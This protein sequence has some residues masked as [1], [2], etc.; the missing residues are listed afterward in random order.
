MSGSELIDLV[1][2]RL[3]EL[4]I[5]YDHVALSDKPRKKIM[6]IIDGKRIDFGAKGS[7][8]WLEGASKQKRD[9]YR[10]RA[11]KITN[12][13]GEYTYLIRYTPNFLAYNILW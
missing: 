2:K 11:S 3:R 7:N 8:T 1:K 5:P 12:K 13:N 9:A 10:A 4:K 6:V